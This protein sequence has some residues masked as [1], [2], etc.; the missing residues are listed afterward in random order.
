MKLNKLAFLFILL[1]LPVLLT[2][3]SKIFPTP[4]GN[5]TSGNENPVDPGN[6]TDTPTDTPVPTVTEIPSVATEIPSAETSGSGTTLPSDN[7]NTSGQGG[8][9]DPDSSSGQNGNSDS[10]SSVDSYKARAEEFL[11]HM[12]LEE[13]VGQ[14]FFVRLRKDSAAADLKDYRLG[15]YILFGDDFKDETKDSIKDLLSEYQ[16]LSSIPLLI[17]VD[18]EG[19]TVNRVSKY[20]AF[21]SEPFKSPQD[22]YKEGG[23]EAI[24]KDTKEKADLLLELG[25]NVNLAP[26][27]DVST[28][29][30]DFIYKRA[31][32]K[33]AKATANY[34]KTVILAMNRARI[35]STLKHFPGYGNNV[36][37]HTGIATD[38]REY[39]QFLKNDFLPFQ[40]G[41]E[42]G[43]DSI[44]VSHNIVTSMDKKYPASLSSAVHEILRDTLNF[45]GVIMTD[46]L[47]MDAIKKYTSNNEAAVLALQAGNDLLIATDFDTQIPAVLEAVK[48]GKIKEDR[49]DDSV[50]RILIWK[51]KLS[52]L[53]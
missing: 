5:N 41:I 6:I 2:G 25:I 27:S 13:K 3:C 32:G 26:V 14:M 34:V 22:L 18:E 44:L 28:D 8:S 46:D 16:D 45:E 12:T 23:F 7:D 30:S 24:Q 9:S 37:T 51:L 15:G 31:F 29:S 4:F 11:S 39:D 1:L 48:S 19:G 49:L 38:N 33:D 53:K 43:A 47:S 42:A 10:D 20:S 52:I 35:G 40:A 50:I 36:D 17:G 21:R